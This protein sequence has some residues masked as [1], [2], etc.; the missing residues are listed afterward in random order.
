MADIYKV[1]KLSVGA[2]LTVYRNKNVSAC[3]FSKLRGLRDLSFHIFDF[4]NI[5]YPV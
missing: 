4:Y 2:W 3:D 1:T 5:F